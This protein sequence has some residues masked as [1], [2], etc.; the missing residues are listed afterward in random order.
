MNE[1]TK[2]MNLTKKSNL[3]VKQKSPKQY[4]FGLFYVKET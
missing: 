3:L 1:L 2:L 4:C